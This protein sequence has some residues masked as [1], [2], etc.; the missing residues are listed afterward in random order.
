MA[1]EWVVENKFVVAAISPF[2]IAA[3]VIKI[4]R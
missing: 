2:I 4:L 1:L 3:I